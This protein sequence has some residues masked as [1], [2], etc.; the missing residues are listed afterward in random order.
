MK[1]NKGKR[2]VVTGASSFVGCH[3]A[4]MLNKA[5]YKVDTVVSP[6]SNRSDIQSKRLAWISSQ[7]IRSHQVDITQAQAIKHFINETRP[8]F[9]IQH[10]GWTAKY[11]QY[12]Y[13]M[14]HASQLNVA[15]LHPIYQALSEVSCQGI[16][17][18]GTE[19]E[20]GESQQAHCEDELFWPTMPYGLSKLSETIYSKQLADHYQLS[21][22]VARLFLPFGPLDNPNKLMPSAIH[23]LLNKQPLEL[24]SSEQY[25]D[26]VYI[27]DVVNAYAL[28]LKDLTRDCIFDI[29]NISS[30]KPQ[31]LKKV[32]LSLAKMID[33]DSQIFQFGS[34]HD[35]GGIIPYIYGS[36]K[37]TSALL[38]WQTIPMEQALKH[39]LKE[40]E[41]E[42]C[43]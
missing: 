30:G 22:R 21:T 17:I 6:R 10:A 12:N 24:T 14:N 7:G 43:L 3:L 23:A 31:Q 36:N 11:N 13:D 38:N 8:D 2:I 18:T 28:L 5:G 32:L 33:A 1:S 37:K 26:F 42:Q 41:N 35:A 19:A 29:F 20:Y 40:V 39:Y 9:W 25:R 4:V 16:I 34:K 15:L 27:D